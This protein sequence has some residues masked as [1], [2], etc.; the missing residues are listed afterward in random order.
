MSRLSGR[1]GFGY[2]GTNHAITT[3]GSSQQTSAF[4]AQTTVVRVICTQNARIA[5]SDNPTASSTSMLIGAGV[6]E[7]FV[8]KGGDKVAVIQ[9][10]AAGNF[11]ATEMT[12]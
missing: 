12:A 1:W 8:V 10:T 4:G 9:D 6:P 2:P 3:S 5:I 7:C 11:T